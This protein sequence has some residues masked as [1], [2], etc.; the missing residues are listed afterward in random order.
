MMVTHGKRVSTDASTRDFG[1]TPI[2]AC[3]PGCQEVP[4]VFEAPITETL[5]PTP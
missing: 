4:F 2:L 3:S 1:E 5:N